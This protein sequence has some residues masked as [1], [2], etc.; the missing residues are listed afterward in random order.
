MLKRILF[1]L[2]LFVPVMFVSPSVL[3]M[4]SLRVKKFI[5]SIFINAQNVLATLMF[6]NVLRSALLIVSCWMPRELNHDSS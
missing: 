5:R 2:V 3:M 6:H 4:Q 1:V